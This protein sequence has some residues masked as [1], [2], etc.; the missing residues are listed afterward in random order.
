GD[1]DVGTRTLPPASV[2]RG[3][4]QD[5]AGLPVAGAIVTVQG[6]DGHSDWMPGRSW[7]DASGDYVV[8]AAPEQIST[9]D[10][11]ADGFVAQMGAGHRALWTLQRGGS[12]AGRVT[13]DQGRPV[14]G[15]VI[16]VDGHSVISDPQGHY[17]VAG[18]SG[19]I[20]IQAGEP[21]GRVAVR[22][23]TIG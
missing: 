23:V 18:V 20:R 4:V 2:V 9:T 15:S 16:T 22:V 10:V 11:R 6:A 13:D 14:S 8:E 17:R 1:I 7:T 21:L 12:I 3:H 19:T 5:R